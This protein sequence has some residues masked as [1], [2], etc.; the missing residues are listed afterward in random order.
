MVDF[1]VT[2]LK[3]IS[4]DTFQKS[5]CH[6]KK[7]NHS[8]W[9]QKFSSQTN[10]RKQI[11]GTL[12]GKVIYTCACVLTEENLISFCC[13][14]VGPYSAVLRAYFWFLDHLW[15]CLG[16]HLGC[17]ESSLVEVPCPLYCLSNP[18]RV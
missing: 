12:F 16:D 3:T 15:Q 13:C 1:W 6:P 8:L 17:Q 9:Q 5:I 7:T 2:T 14:F 11:M 4:K 10:T 18:Q